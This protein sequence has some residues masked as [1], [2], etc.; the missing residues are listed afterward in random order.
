[1]DPRGKMNTPMLH[2]IHQFHNLKT[3]P[4]QILRK[5]KNLWQNWAPLRRSSFI[6]TSQNI[7]AGT[8]IYLTWTGFL[9]TVDHFFSLPLKR[10]WW[11][12]CQNITSKKIEGICLSISISLSKLYFLYPT[13][14]HEFH[15]HHLKFKVNQSTYDY[16]K[17]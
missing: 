13:A 17:L 4:K 6:W 11:K 5:Q 3:K 1:M 15:I 10:M 9:A 12:I 7:M 14:V 8:V 2:F 16:V